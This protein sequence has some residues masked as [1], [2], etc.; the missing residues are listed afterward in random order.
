MSL[1]CIVLLLLSQAA[2]ELEV[3]VFNADDEGEQE[4][5][6]FNDGASL[7]A[8]MNVADMDA[9]AKQLRSLL[10]SKEAG[11]RCATPRCIIFT[12]YKCLHCWHV[13]SPGL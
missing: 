2:M 1:I 6:I 7:G 3:R 11:N 4:L 5:Y 9:L 13:C 10:T 8:T 12:T